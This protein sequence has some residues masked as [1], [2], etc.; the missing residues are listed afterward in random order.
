MFPAAAGS[1]GD[2]CERDIYG[3][4]SY[5]A[6]VTL[7]YGGSGRRSGGIFRIDDDDHGFLLPFFGVRGRFTIN[8][9]RHRVHLPEVWHNG[10]CK[11][12]LLVQSDPMGGFTTDSGS[13][14]DIANRGKELLDYCAHGML[15][16]VIYSWGSAF[17]RAIIAGIGS[18][19][20]V[21]VDKNGTTVNSSANGGIGNLSHA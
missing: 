4:P 3:Q 12:A 9:W 7:L 11:I 20:L 10:E 14:A 1:P 6:C 2:F 15:N 21:G 16:I 8:Q 19:G 5:A 13:W 17:D 18:V